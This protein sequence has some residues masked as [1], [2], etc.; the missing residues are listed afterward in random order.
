MINSFFTNKGYFG[1]NIKVIEKEE[2]LKG[3]TEIAEELNLFFSKTVKSLNIAENTYE[4]VSDN[5]LDLV[6]RAI[7]NFKTHSSVL[8]IEKNISSGK[9]F[10]F[11]GIEKEYKEFKC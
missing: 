4:K 3:D 2:I 8:M 6:V 10:S 11:T 9:I 1:G 5:L 7:E